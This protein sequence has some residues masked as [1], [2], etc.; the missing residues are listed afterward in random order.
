ME[1]KSKLKVLLVLSWFL[2]LA[3]FITSCEVFIPERDF[4]APPAP[5]PLNPNLFS[6]RVEGEDGRMVELSGPSSN[7][8]PGGEVFYQLSIYNG[9][10][11]LW[12]DSYCLV[13]TGTEGIV[14]LLDDDDFSLA[15]ADGI[16]T[17]LPVTFPEELE[18]SLYALSFIIKDRWSS[19]NTVYFINDTHEPVGPW[20]NV[21]CP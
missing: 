6:M 18:Q 2:L 9:G 21:E 8:Q 5:L 15:P 7:L 3:F 17:N 13:L 1:K 20:P 19:L 11:D 10:E 16:N 12:Q 14:A 4:Q